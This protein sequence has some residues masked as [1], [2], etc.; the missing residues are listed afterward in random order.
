VLI[1]ANTKQQQPADTARL[2][3]T[4]PTPGGAYISFRDGTANALADLFVNDSGRLHLG[5]P[6]LVGGANNT[7]VGMGT[8]ANIGGGT[9][10]TAMGFNA[11]HNIAGGNNNTVI[12]F[13]AGQSITNGSNNTFIGADAAGG[14]ANVDSGNNNTAIGFDACGN[15]NGANNK[16][17]IGANSRIAG[18]PNNLPE[19]YIG[20]ASVP[21]DVY[22]SGTLFT[23]AVQNL[24]DK[25][26]KNIINDNTDGLDKVAQLKV[27]NFTMKEDKENTP[28]VGVVAQ[29]LQKVFPKAVHTLPNGTLT[30]DKDYILF[31]M[32]NAVKELDNKIND[33]VKRVQVLEAQ[34][35]QLIEQGKSL[36]TRIAKL[37]SKVK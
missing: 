22:V 32:V 35:K 37:E 30:I 10:N 13:Q 27:F 16:T 33:V 6:H 24:S 2:I 15:L 4:Q 23:N 9:N 28:R 20:S 36:E 19:V 7:S 34:H 21:S 31:A 26:L 11:G 3:I 29:D 25:R 17:C 5:T 1:G 18:A 12:G 8:L 14:S